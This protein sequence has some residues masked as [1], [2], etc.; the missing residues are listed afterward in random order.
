MDSELRGKMG[1]MTVFEKHKEE[2]EGFEK[3]YSGKT[4]RLVFAMCILS[5]IYEILSILSLRNAEK[6]I[7]EMLTELNEV[8]ELLNSFVKEE[9]GGKWE[10]KK[11]RKK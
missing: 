11:S 5:D 6:V 4:G 8:Q 9:L 2:L 7:P 1:M 10:T 3:L